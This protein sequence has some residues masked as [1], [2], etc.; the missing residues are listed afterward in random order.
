MPF[1]AFQPPSRTGRA[2]KGWRRAKKLN[3]IGRT[4]PEFKDLAQSSG[5]K[6]ITVQKKMY[7]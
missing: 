4:D 3:L 7:P 5:W 1:G 6:M 2:R